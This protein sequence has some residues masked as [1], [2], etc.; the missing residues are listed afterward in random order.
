MCPFACTRTPAHEHWQL[1]W[2]TAQVWALSDIHADYGPNRAWM[3]A[4]PSRKSESPN[5]ALSVL[6]VAGD[7]AT[8]IRV[9]TLQCHALHNNFPC[10]SPKS[11]TRTFSI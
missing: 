8:G 1:P 9:P 10:P 4:L 5:D 6:L 7:V 2:L 11:C 3:E